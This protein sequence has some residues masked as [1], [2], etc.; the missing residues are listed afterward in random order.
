MYTC[1]CAHCKQL[2]R[3]LIGSG[4]FH[5]VMHCRFIICMFFFLLFTSQHRE[6]LVVHSRERLVSQS[7]F[8]TPQSNLRQDRPRRNSSPLISPPRE[9]DLALSTACCV[10]AFLTQL[11]RAVNEETSSF[12][13]LLVLTVCIYF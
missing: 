13:D 3:L 12:T 8:L 10:V 9:E 7:V 11:L 6:R 4:Y 2:S 1:L 5:D